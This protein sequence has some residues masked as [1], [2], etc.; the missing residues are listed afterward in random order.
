MENKMEMKDFFDLSNKGFSSTFLATTVELDIDESK[1]ILGKYKGIEFPVIFKQINGKKMTDILETGY[2]SLF[3][4][5]NKLIA[6]LEENHFTGW[7]IYPIKL[8]DKKENEIKGY[9]GFSVI[10]ICG[11]LSY[12]DSTII[13]KRVVPGGP[14]CKF[15]KGVS[16]GL[17]E[18]DGS[19][20]FI[21]K[22]TIKIVITKK[23]ADTLKSNKISNIDLTNLAE[24]EKLI[25]SSE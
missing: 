17:G 19:D 13:V 10:G 20:F 12:K 21:P 1:L 15:Y 25:F 4:V 9:Y 2:P 3:I 23:V 14:L 5:S 8:L 7:K 16:I 24:Q 22:N 18:W 6:L 11:P